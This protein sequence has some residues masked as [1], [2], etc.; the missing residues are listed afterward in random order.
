MA[1][2]QQ[3]EGKYD[4]AK[5]KIKQAVGDATD[6]ENLQAEGGLDR[7]KGVVKEGV[8]NLKEAVKKTVDGK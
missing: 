6:N 5:G 4:Q 2:E 1:N 7:A 3:V 8:G